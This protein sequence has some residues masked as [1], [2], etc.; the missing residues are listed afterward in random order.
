MA[1]K[2][3]PEVGW[4]GTKNGATHRVWLPQAAQAIIA[5]LS[6]GETT[7][8]VFEGGGGA[9]ADLGG[10]ALSAPRRMIFAERTAPPSPG[11]GSAARQ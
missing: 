8:F 9:I 1:G 6:D 7:G 2:P 5:E 3:C 10:S 11:S 4:P